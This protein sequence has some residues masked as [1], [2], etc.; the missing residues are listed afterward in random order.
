[1][2]YVYCE[3]FSIQRHVVLFTGTPPKRRA[4]PRFSNFG[5]KITYI[6]WEWTSSLSG[7]VNRRVNR[8]WQRF[9]LSNMQRKKESKRIEMT[10]K[11]VNEFKLT[12][13]HFAG[14]NP[15]QICACAWIYGGTKKTVQ[16]Q[17][18]ATGPPRRRAP[19]PLGLLAAGLL[20]AKPKY[21]GTKLRILKSL[22]LALA[23]SSCM[24]QLAIDVVNLASLSVNLPCSRNGEVFTDTPL[25]TMYWMRNPLSAKIRS[26]GTKCC[27]KPV[28]WTISLS[29]MDPG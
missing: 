3:S 17:D 18:W 5:L 29:E 6:V 7:S 1:M 13:V 14:P 2:R 22:S 24:R 16:N 21:G 19:G 9:S 23:L 26:P 12:V 15:I 11:M 27:R 25:G 8:E 4:G 10:V 20:L 28:C